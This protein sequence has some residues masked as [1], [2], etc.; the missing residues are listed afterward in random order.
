MQALHLQQLQSELFQMKQPL[1][2]TESMSLLLESLGSSVTQV[3]ML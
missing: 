2:L 1:Q 3:K